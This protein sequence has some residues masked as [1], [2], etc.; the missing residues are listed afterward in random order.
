MPQ[1][2][3]IVTHAQRG[4]SWMAPDA[5][6][7]DLL[8]VSNVNGVVNVYRYW[9][10][11]LAGVLTDFD[12]PWG[13]CVDESGDVYIADFDGR[14][15]VE[16]AHGGTKPIATIDTTP[17]RPY[18]CAVDLKSGTLAVVNFSGG[19]DHRGNIAIYLHGTGK[20][21]YYTY[22]YDHFESCGYDDRGDLLAA[23]DRPQSDS[24][25]TTFTYLTKGSRKLRIMKL[26][27][28]SASWLWGGIEAIQFD[29]KYWVVDDGESLYRYKI[30][31][32]AQYIDTIALSAT[33]D[34]FGPIWLYRRSAGVR[35]SQVVSGSVR[36][37]KDAVDY[38]D[39]PAGGTPIAT[40]TKGLD[41]PYGVAISLRQ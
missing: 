37:S 19:P 26:P 33:Y 30:N 38:W 5:G 11:T 3:A 2:R 6:Q 1:G 27:G 32:A 9:Q 8:Y 22:L 16:Y 40:M 41:R 23:S 21:T 4:G 28:P 12:L 36:Q 17:Y 18:G 24:Y 39:Y 29:G 15:V 35:A 10:H 20:P 34:G 31:V 13:E 25:L 7:R 14:K